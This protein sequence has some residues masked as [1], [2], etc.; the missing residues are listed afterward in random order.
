[1]LLAVYDGHGLVCGTQSL[2]MPGLRLTV[3]FC[4]CAFGS[5]GGSRYES[6]P[7]YSLKR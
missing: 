2:G 4:V 1:M 5:H 3:P 6:G 7:D